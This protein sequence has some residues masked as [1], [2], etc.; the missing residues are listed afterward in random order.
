M[1][2]TDNK[3]ELHTE[4]SK[5]YSNLDIKEL[6]KDL[7]TVMT[8]SQD[9]WP[10]DYNHYGP[11]F[12]RMAW[13]SAGTYRTYDGR[14][15]SGTGQLRYA[16]LNSWPDNG[17]LDKA[18]RLLWP[19][20]KK[21]GNQI[22]WADLM[23]YSGNVAYESMGLK[24]FGFGGGRVDVTTPEDHIY[25]GSESEWLSAERGGVGDKLNQPLGAVQMGLI[26]VNP[27]GPNG[28]PDFLKSAE[29]IRATFGR[30]AMNDEETVA[31][32]AGGH[33]VGKAHGA[34]D[35]DQHVGPAPEGNANLEDAGFGWMSSYK[36]GKGVDA[37]TSGLEGAW[38][39]DPIKWDNG[40]FENLFNYE[41]EQTTSPAGAIQFRP[42][43][44]SSDDTVPD[45]HDS[46]QRH[47]PIM[48]TTDIALIKDPA[49]LEISKK[50]YKNPELLDDVFAKAWYKL[51]HRDLGPV[52]RLLG[53]EVAA[54][55]I[56]Q[57]PKPNH[58]TDDNVQLVNDHEIEL[59]KKTIL[60]MGPDGGY[61][62][63]LLRTAWG[64]ATTYRKTDMR[65]GSHDGRIFLAPQNQWESNEPNDLK[66]IETTLKAVQ[67]HFNNNAT[68]NATISMADLVVLGGCAVVEQ[69]A[70]A[71]GHDVV[72]PFTPGRTDASDTETDTASF[73]VLEP[74]SD[75][76]RNYMHPNNEKL[77]NHGNPHVKTS[78]EALLVDR[79]FMLNLTK[80]EMTVLV[81][82]MR[83]IGGNY[84]DSTV[85]VLTETPGTLTND[86]F[87]NLLDM[88]TEWKKNEKD[89]TLYDGMDRSTGELK[90]TGSRIDLIFASNSELRACSENYACDDSEELF[91]HD[92]VAAWSKC[93]ENGRF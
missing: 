64:S 54:P 2:K 6:K 70:T 12:I 73:D 5:H 83:T 87:V 45:A 74:T 78:P 18:R 3:T 51:T 13:H 44:R 38:T 69:A 41:W 66:Q 20:K 71:A 33:T 81:G 37:I 75:G 55:Q 63:Q 91:V 52:D 53:S 27:Q 56:W 24:T 34:G 84:Q 77:P 25:W 22:S 89:D 26:Y 9:W 80:E 8:T 93:M 7:F 68:S 30:M 11:F 79:A 72:V 60:S 39:K 21:Y 23:I 28:V 4:Y 92:F 88:N 65:G 15:G 50:F 42:T 67:T 29:D 58:N 43:D 46:T 10:A 35:A 82:G 86:Y 61:H 16:P 62:N 90:W 36:S 1:S 57:D 31:L 14:G 40:Y 19:I 47:A 76:F 59:L 85:G 32:I 17:N 49:Y 48:F